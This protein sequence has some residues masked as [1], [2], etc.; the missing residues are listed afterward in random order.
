MRW[1]DA[2]HGPALLAALVAAALWLSVSAQPAH[3]SDSG[4]VGEYYVGNNNGSSGDKSG[5]GSGSDGGGLTADPDTFK[6]DT[7][8]GA[9]IG[10]TPPPVHTSPVSGSFGVFLN[11]LFALLGARYLAGR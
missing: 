1:K 9:V 2:L 10:A 6:I 11:W 8:G 4:N 3:A 5:A 7:W